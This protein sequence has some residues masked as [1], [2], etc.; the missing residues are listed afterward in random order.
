MFHFSPQKAQGECQMDE[1]QMRES[2]HWRGAH[3]E[4][5]LSLSRSMGWG[6]VEGEGLGG[7]RC[8]VKVH[9]P[10]PRS[11]RKRPQNGEAWAR[12]RQMRVWACLT[13]CGGGRGWLLSATRSRKLQCTCGVQRANVP[14]SPHP[15]YGLWLGLQDHTER[16][17]LEGIPHL[18]ESCLYINITGKASP[19]S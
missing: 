8:C 6:K 16:V 2:W 5:L 13:W 18:E 3:T 12:N 14:L 7:E 19:R 17:D 9:V 1:A 15:C 10:Q 11:P 4:M